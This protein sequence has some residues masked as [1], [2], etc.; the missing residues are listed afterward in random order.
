MRIFALL[1][2]ALLFLTGDSALAH[3]YIVRA[4]PADRSVLTRPPTRLQYWFSEDLEPGF[5]SLALRDQTGQILTEGGVTENDESLM[6]LRVPPALPDGAYIVELRTAFASDGHVTVESRVFFVGEQVSG[7]FGTAASDQPQPL[8]VVWR[9][10]LYPSL[11]LL[12]GTFTLY[13]LVLVPA[14]GSAQHRAGL[15]PPRVMRRLSAI[16]IAALVV[17]FGA[18]LLA[19]VQQTMVFFS[20]DAG[21]AISQGLWQI[22]RIGSRFGD[23]WNARM[24]LLVVIAVLHGVS[25]YWRESQPETV[26][27]FWLANLWA[28]A[29]ALGT[30]SA[31]S[32]AAGSLLHPWLAVIADFLHVL[33]VGAW[34]GGLAALVLILPAALSPYQG[35]ERRLA[36][37]AVLRRFSLLAMAGLAT[38]ITTGIYS[39]S[40]WLYTPGDLTATTYGGT[41]LIKLLLVGGLVAVG[42]LNFLVLQ[43]ER[44]ARWN[45][46]AARVQGFIPT[47]QIEAILA[48]LIVVS[49]ALLAAT[50]VPEP[51]F[52]ETVE[53]PN[54][55]QTVNGLD[56][57]LTI[58]PGGTGIN[59]YDTLIT[60]GD[61]GEEG[62]EVRVRMANPARDWRG[63]WSDAETIG[64]G[65]YVSA[66]DE[67]DQPDVWWTLIDITENGETTRAAFAWEI[68]AAASVRDTRDFTPIHALALLGVVA[69]VIFAAMPV[70]RR[71]NQNAEWTTLN[72]TVALAAVVGTGILLIVA[73]AALQASQAQYDAIQNPLP[74]IINPTLPD[75]ASLERGRDLFTQHCAEWQDANSL[76][77]RLPR[78]R[79]E[80]LFTTMLEGGLSLPPCAE[81]TDLERWDTVNFV[82]TL[83]NEP[84]VTSS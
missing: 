15:L 14:W 43:P 75:Q 10:L 44:Y 63:A 78:L 67:I 53:T 4:I 50:P 49:T 34:A 21:T 33:A 58:S 41:L 79:D 22:V 29:L 24:L 32:H 38:V 39:A 83:S 19:L 12:L 74:Q 51:P 68:D 69:G 76:R 13:S 11:L 5:S 56:V 6:T 66:G 60:R 30:F 47:L 16:I 23:V 57:T 71:L 9:A 45:S 64:D 8:E 72:I 1:F 46:I 40:N 80:D 77:Q 82:R 61:T 20:V 42:G 28:S 36:L 52:I 31:A 27:P 81:M 65:L 59:T 48:G 37:L 73:T 7:I 35:D 2:V 62:L 84:L 25:I 55:A 70:L 18:N 54:A 3:G 17:A 26:R